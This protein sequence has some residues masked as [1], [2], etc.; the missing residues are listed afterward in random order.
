MFRLGISPFLAVFLA[1]FVLWQGPAVAAAVPAPPGNRNVVQPPIPSGSISRTRATKGSFEEK[2]RKIR[3]LI[4]SDRKLRRQIEKSAARFGIDPIHIVGALVGEHTYNVDALDYFQTYFVK[5][6]SYLKSAIQFQFEGEAVSDFVQRPQFSRCS[7]IT[8]SYELW[9]CREE[10]WQT[11]FAG[12]TIGGTRF[13]NDRFSKVFFQPLYAGQT[14]GLGQLNPLTALRATDMVAEVTRRKKLNPDNAPEVYAA[15]MAPDSTLDYMAA[16]L[17]IAI[18][19]YRDHAGVDIS[20]NPG[21]TATLYNLGDVVDRARTLAE[22]RKTDPSVM[23]EE[24]YYGWLVND[25][26]NELLPLVQ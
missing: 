5:A 4:A 17:K 1:V 23:P 2:Y 12:K 8:G 26:L 6:A 21:L 22:K 7:G 11:E 10:V 20:G 25:K 3:D 15:I 13:P 16:V 9:N 19:A 18:D 24:N 14:F